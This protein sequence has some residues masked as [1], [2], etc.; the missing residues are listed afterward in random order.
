MKHPEMESFLEDI[1]LE[2]FGRSA[3]VAK[4]TQSCVS[5]GGAASEFKDAVSKKEYEISHLCQKCQDEIFSSD[6][7]N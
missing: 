3:G 7:D 6:T 4:A 2:L 1:S 5:C